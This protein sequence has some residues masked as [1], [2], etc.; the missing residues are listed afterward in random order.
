MKDDSPSATAQIV[1]LNVAL[2]AARPGIGHLVDPETR[3][4]NA[5][6][7]AF[8]RRA[9]FWLA[10]SR[11]P[12]FHRL[13]EA[14]ESR[15]VPGMALHQVLRKRWLEQAVEQGLAEGVR[16]VV[17][18]GGG[19][20]T[21]AA[22]LAR[23]HPSTRFLEADH[24]ATQA[25]KRAA[26]D[27]AGYLGPNLALAAVDFN[28]TPLGDALRARPEFRPDVPTLFL[29]EGVLMY[30]EPVAVD[31]LFAALRALP[32][33]SLRFAF[34]YMEPGADGSIAFA[35][36]RPVVKAWL[37]WRKEAFTW[38][39]ARRDLEGFLASRGFA[40]E[41]AADDGTLRG[42]FLQGMPEARIA[43][44][45]KLA[46]ATRGAASRPLD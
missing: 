31:R 12:W 28:R 30:L 41:Q 34:T 13:F 36:S 45:E 10:L 37:R 15:V 43:A 23:R 17:V 32:C 25:V 9:R 29:C 44:G 6:F 35:G 46:L 20:D 19:L 7:L 21:L 26:L 24:P 27:R 14:F 42:L 40:L 3:A 8:S 5:E 22:R 33:P 39:L 4:L 2:V 1:A 18:L 38:G 16:Q 11:H